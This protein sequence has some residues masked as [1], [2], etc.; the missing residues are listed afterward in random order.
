MASKLFRLLVRQVDLYFTPLTI[1]V[2]KC[3]RYRVYHADVQLV[4][5]G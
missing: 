1:D 5:Q 2:G 4:Q 3:Q